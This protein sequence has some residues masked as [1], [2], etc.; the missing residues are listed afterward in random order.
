M[1]FTVVYSPHAAP[2]RYNKLTFY[3]WHNIVIMINLKSQHHGVP[4]S[5]EILFFDKSASRSVQRWP[6]I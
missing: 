4:I 2:I 6:N 1:V 5:Y 3:V